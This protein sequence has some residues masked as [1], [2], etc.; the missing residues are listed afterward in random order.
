MSK[1]RGVKPKEEEKRLKMFV[2]GPAGIGKTS[3]ALQFPKNY[4]FDLEK[5]TDHYSKTINKQNSVVFQSNNPDEIKEEIHTLLTEKNDFLTVTIDPF[6]QL[7]NSVQEKWNRKFISYS[8]EKKESDMQDFGPRYWGKVK[9]EIKS[10][11][12]MLLTGDFNLI[13]TS[14]QKDLYGPN[15]TKLGTSFDSMKGDDYLYDY[16]FRIDFVNEKRMAFTI[17]ERSEIGEQKFPAMFEWSYENFIKYY[18]KK[19]LEKESS[20]IKMATK[21]EVEKIHNLLT[22]VKVEEEVIS[23]WMSKV[24]ADSFEEFTEEQILKCI[25]VLEDKL[26]ELK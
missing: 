3:A 11:Q 23:K 18:G 10:I 25:K 7:Y 14:H 2:Y 4:I 17:K 22:I 20:P 1:L 21:K 5:G 6:T 26:K 8:K 12:R 16:I 24:D 19:I 15:M 9:S 13:V